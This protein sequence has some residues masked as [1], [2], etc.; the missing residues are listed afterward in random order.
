MD[1]PNYNPTKLTEILS[2]Y[3][4]VEMSDQILSGFKSPQKVKNAS[5]TLGN[6]SKI[7]KSKS[8]YT[9]GLSGRL[10]FEDDNMSLEFPNAILSNQITNKESFSVINNSQPA[11]TITGFSKD[12]YFSKALDKISSIYELIDQNGR[13]VSPVLQ[14]KFDYKEVGWNHNE[15]KRDYYDEKEFSLNGDI[16][17]GFV[18][19]HNNKELHSLEGLTNQKK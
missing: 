11:I 6:V 18:L 10:E 3:H 17:S 15:S 4:N 8:N 1:K 19:F 12:S 14:I 5:L 7:L 9:I 16:K 2:W 13:Y